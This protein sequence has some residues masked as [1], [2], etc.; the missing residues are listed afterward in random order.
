MARVANV[1]RRLHGV[2]DLHQTVVRQAIN[3]LGAGADHAPEGA[4]ALEIRG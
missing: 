1:L 2:F 3:S 4:A